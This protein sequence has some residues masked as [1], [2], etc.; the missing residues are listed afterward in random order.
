MRDWGITAGIAPQVPETLV[1]LLAALTFLGSP[2]FLAVGIPVLA[3]AGTYRERLDRRTALRLVAVLILVLG[4][5]S[6]LKNGL[7]LPRPPAALH[8]IPEDGYGFPSGHATAITGAALA[9]AGLVDI[10]SRR[11]RFALA[12]VAIAVIAAT[13]VLLGVHYVAD[14]LAGVVVGAVVVAVGIHATDRYPAGASFT[15]AATAVLGVL[16]EFPLGMG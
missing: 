11:R 13:R 12:G 1:P 14:V 16:L 2:T 4:I 7:A 15:V 9:L 5:S 3:A 10:G 8:R 6:I